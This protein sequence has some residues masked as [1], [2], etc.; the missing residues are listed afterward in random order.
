MNDRTVHLGPETAESTALADDAAID[1]E[2]F[3]EREKTRLFQALWW[4]LRAVRADGR[5][6]AS[7]DSR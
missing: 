1:F 6:S 2:A 4:T 5:N 7:P 3:F